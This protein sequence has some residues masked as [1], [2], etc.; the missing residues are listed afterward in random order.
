MRRGPYSQFREQELTLRD[1]LAI[2]R[3]TLANERTL[4]AYAR[5]ALA[6][7]VVGG[8]GIKFFTSSWIQIAGVV[9]IAAGVLVTL[10]GWQRYTH[11]KRLLA[12][13]LERPADTAE[14]SPARP[15]APRSEAPEEGA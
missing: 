1:Y 11:T 6:L 4:L 12:P 14:R 15:A 13:V 10:R 8:T 9:I 2:D 5:T 7:V 3:T